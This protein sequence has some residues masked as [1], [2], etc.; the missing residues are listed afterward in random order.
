MNTSV[1]KIVS[2]SPWI[3]A[4]SS[5]GG[6]DWGNIPDE[7]TFPSEN[8]K[9]PTAPGEIVEKPK[10]VGEKVGTEETAAIDNAV[11]VALTSH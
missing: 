10:D 1:I 9:I 2:S 8:A 6:P 11:I 5:V 4:A 3:L 7:S